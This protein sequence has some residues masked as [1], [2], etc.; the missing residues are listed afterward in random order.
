MLRGSQRKALYK[1]VMRVA[2]PGLLGPVGFVWI[3]AS[4]EGGR[5]EEGGVQA[6]RIESRGER[7]VLRP[8]VGRCQVVGIN[9]LGLRCQDVVRIELG[10]ELE[11]G[12][13][14][15]VRGSLFGCPGLS[16]PEVAVPV[17]GGGRSRRI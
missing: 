4:A 11:G 12:I 6:R 5:L 1:S 7:F 17:R 13:V 9:H 10:A 16:S 8:E 15:P 2:D 14:E 3:D